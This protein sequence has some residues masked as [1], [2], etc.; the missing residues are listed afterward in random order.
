MGIVQEPHHFDKDCKLLIDEF[1]TKFLYSIGTRS[2]I[3][4][5]L[6]IG[7]CVVQSV[8]A[9]IVKTEHLS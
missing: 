7:I 6:N 9:M 2:S 1:Q 4:N 8:D 3:N 5:C